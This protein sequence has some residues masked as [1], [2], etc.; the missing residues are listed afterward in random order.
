M[1]KLLSI[2]SF[3]CFLIACDANQS[4]GSSSRYEFPPPEGYFEQLER[5]EKVEPALVHDSSLFDIGPSLYE[6]GRKTMWRTQELFLGNSCYRATIGP[7]NYLDQSETTLAYFTIAVVA[8]R[9]L[10][11]H[12]GSTSTSWIYFYQR[13]IKAEDLPISILEKNISEVVSFDESTKTANFAVGD[14]A[15]NYVLK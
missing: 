5:C 4:G 13:D 3:T 2:L 15:Y 9:K 14:K 6:K 12:D 7:H 11:M 10:K 8:R 1:I